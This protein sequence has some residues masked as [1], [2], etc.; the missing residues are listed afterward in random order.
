MSIDKSAY[1]VAAPSGDFQNPNVP[2]LRQFR[3]VKDVVKALIVAKNPEAASLNWANFNV[4]VNAYERKLILTLKEGYELVDRYTMYEA[5]EF[6]Y[7]FGE[8]GKELDFNSLFTQTLGFSLT[9]SED[10]YDAV[11][12]ALD[13][14]AFETLYAPETQELTVTVKATVNTF[15]FSTDNA[16]LVT[17]LFPGK[18]VVIQFVDD[19]IE[20]TPKFANTDLVITMEDLLEAASGG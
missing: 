6:T 8:S 7:G 19:A 11:I 20:V 1:F 10:Q 4:A 5:K 18:S 2:A 3:K 16:T 14:N 15:D 17:A 12:A 9:Y 13:S